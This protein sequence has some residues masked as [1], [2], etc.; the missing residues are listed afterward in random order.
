VW[1]VPDSVWVRCLVVLLVLAA[2]RP[3]ATLA[4]VVPVQGQLVVG[5][6]L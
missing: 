2:M 3:V 5:L 4:V 1:L 6:V